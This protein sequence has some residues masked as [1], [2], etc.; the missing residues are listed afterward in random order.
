MKGSR[1]EIREEIMQ[2]ATAEMNTIPKE[3]FQKVAQDLLDT[4]S[5]DP[6]FLNTVITGDESWVYGYDL[7]TKAQSLQW[8]HPKSPRLK[9]VRQVQS[10]IKV[11]LT[12][13]FDIHGIVHHEYAPVG[14]TVTKVYYQQILR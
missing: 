13:F 9:K 11:M 2:N 5:T 3:A 8:K 12:V 6:E 1:F 4:T 14:Q 7:E 10:K